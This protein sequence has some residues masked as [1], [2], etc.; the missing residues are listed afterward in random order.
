MT[1]PRRHL[2]PVGV[3][4]PFA[5]LPVDWLQDIW[6]FPKGELPG[7]GGSLSQ[8]LRF[9]WTGV[10]PSLAAQLKWA[11]ATRCLSGQWRA[12][13]LIAVRAVVKDLMGFLR[14]DAPEVKSLLDRDSEAWVLRFRSHLIAKGT[15]RQTTIRALVRSAPGG[16][17]E[18]IHE[19]NAVL[20][21]RQLYTMVAEELDS[22]DEYEK[23]VWSLRRLGI[24]VRASVPIR[25]LRFTRLT[26]PWLK[27]AIKHYCQYTLVRGAA[28]SC[29]E[30]ILVAAKFSEY[31]AE[32]YPDLAGSEI[33]RQVLLGFM[34]FLERE[35]YS[36]N[37]RYST[38]IH[39]I[40]GAGYSREPPDRGS[41]VFVRT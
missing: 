13:L 30:W 17:R 8:P 35:G 41:R 3:V 7:V 39:Q 10:Q 38:I 37:G 16:V 6:T 9:D 1:T 22:R 29:Q 27:D 20:V 15:Y 36:P 11:I 5:N 31:L 12:Q 26:Q 21:F 33:N 24:A 28:S 25:Y 18:Y 2:E 4:E 14:E 32:K 23:D 40:E 34:A 19:D